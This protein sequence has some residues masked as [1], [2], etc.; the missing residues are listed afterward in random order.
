[1]AERVPL[2]VKFDC[3]HITPFKV[4]TT[5]KKCDS[6]VADYIDVRNQ[7]KRHIEIH[8]QCHIDDTWHARLIAKNLPNNYWKI[9][10]NLKFITSEK[11]ETLALLIELNKVPEAQE[12]LS[13]YNIEHSQWNW[14]NKM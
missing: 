9:I 5:V 1:M 11:V 2:V 7:A 10:K 14:S 8:E 6:A 12:L 3:E 13:I 4:F